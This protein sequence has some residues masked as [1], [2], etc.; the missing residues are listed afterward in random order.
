M[1]GLKFTAASKTTGR[2]KK[3]CYNDFWLPVTA[4]FSGV[5]AW[6]TLTH[7]PLLCVLRPEEALRVS[8]DIWQLWCS[9]VLTLFYYWPRFSGS[10]R[11]EPQ[12]SST[13]DPCLSA[14][15]WPLAAAAA[16]AKERGT[17]AVFSG[18]DYAYLLVV[19]TEK[20]REM[21]RDIGAGCILI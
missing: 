21:D 5:P 11:Q 7:W 16:A 18:I 2:D 17:S 1:P 9:S 20:E 14:I 6:V 3:V 8:M 19:W 10:Q 4:C 12:H 15:K 13:S